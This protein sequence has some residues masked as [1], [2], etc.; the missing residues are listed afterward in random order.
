MSPYC[1]CYDSSI[2]SLKLV[3]VPIGSNCNVRLGYGIGEPTPVSD[4]PSSSCLNYSTSFS[5][6]LA[7]EAKPSGGTPI[8]NGYGLKLLVYGG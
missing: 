1:Y 7:V 8:G 5:L 6:V 3:V 4:D 2:Q